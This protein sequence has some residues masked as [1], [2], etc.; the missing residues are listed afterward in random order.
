MLFS[1]AVK[2]D[3][4]PRGGQKMDIY[5]TVC[6]LIA[7]SIISCIAGGYGVATSTLVGVPDALIPKHFPYISSVARG[8]DGN[9]L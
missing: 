3:F 9:N 6:L 2:G 7:V 8:F 1:R 5:K 4:W